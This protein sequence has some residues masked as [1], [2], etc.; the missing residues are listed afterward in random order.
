MVMSDVR[1]W[2]AGEAAQE[3]VRLVERALRD[4][5]AVDL[6]ALCVIAGRKVQTLDSQPQT[7]T[8]A[9]SLASPCRP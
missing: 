3:V 9:D 5:H 6:E 7:T 8:R 1:A 4:S 2:G